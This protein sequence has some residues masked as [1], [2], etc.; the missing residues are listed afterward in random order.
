MDLKW[1]PGYRIVWIECDGH[2]LHIEN[3]AT[4][5]G[6]SCNVKDVVLEPPVEFW[7]IDTQFGR[8]RKYINHP[9]NIPTITL[10][11]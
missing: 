3:Q 8:A 11:K 10:N 5:K 9:A 2:F 6:R 7:N 4:R 1:R